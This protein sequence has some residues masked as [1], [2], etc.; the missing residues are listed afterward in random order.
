[1]L[2]CDESS[3]QLFTLDDVMDSLLQLHAIVYGPGHAFQGSLTGLWGE[4]S[5]P[6]EQA[7][8]QEPRP[9]PEEEPPKQEQSVEDAEGDG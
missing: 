2:L 8:P 9:V 3:D 6:A 5:L 1:M 7:V 4:Q